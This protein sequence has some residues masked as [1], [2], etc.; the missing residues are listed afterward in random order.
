VTSGG[1][2]FELPGV[3]AFYLALYLLTLIVHV[4]FMNYV[5]AGSGYLAFVSLFTGGPH[6][7]RQ[8]SATALVLRDWMP[9]AVSAA[10]TAGVAPLLFI[11]ILY[12]RAFYTANL[13]LFHRWMAILPVL[14]VGFYLTY[15]LKSRVIGGW[16]AVLRAAVGV[17]AAACFLFTAWS[18]TENHLLSLREVGWPE[19]AAANRLVYFE[20]VLIPR[21]V[22]WCAGA[23]PTMVLIVS[24]QLWH[25]ERSRGEP[26][27][28]GEVRVAAAMVWGGLLCAALAA[29][30]YVA[31]S[32]TELRAEFS[33]GE[34]LTCASATVAG[35]AVLAVSWIGPWRSS[36][37]GAGGLLAGSIAWFIAIAGMTLLREI[38][39]LS[40]MNLAALQENHARAAA[41]GGL[42]VFAFF[43]VVNV[44]LIAWCFRLVRRGVR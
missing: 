33:T 12:Q 32:P 19:F 43:L 42:Y 38:Q 5:L 8:K 21:L 4:V 7:R 6:R 44:V 26:T 25:Q 39:R 16:P 17:G 13:L 23:L 36:R 35:A 20:P 22:L 18:W 29:G 15:V 3:T 40:C 11:Q 2:L 24:W 10:I 41:R 1:V 28:P 14:I 31:L 30:V 9:F 34:A 27:P 37:L